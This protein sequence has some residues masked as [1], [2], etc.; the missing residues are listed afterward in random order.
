MHQLNELESQGSDR[1]KEIVKLVQSINE[2]AQ[3]F[4]EL[5]MLVLEQVCSLLLALVCLH[6]ARCQGSILD[7]IDY[8][9][10]MAKLK[11]EQGNQELKKVFERAFS[12]AHCR[13]FV[14][15]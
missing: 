14:V 15:L 4:R 10:E 6:W 13:R 3:V 7:R 2:L 9:I 5:N 11:V 8:N 1:E 12:A